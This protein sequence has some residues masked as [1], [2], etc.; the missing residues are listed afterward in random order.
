MDPRKRTLRRI[1]VGELEAAE[2]VFDLLM[3]SEVAPRRDF[4]IAGAAQLDR[5]R[6]DA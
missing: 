1:T 5:A 2:Q 3:G 4:I 6:I